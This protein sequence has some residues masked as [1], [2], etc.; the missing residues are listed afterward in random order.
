[1]SIEE[2]VK[3]SEK[4]CEKR[5]TGHFGNKSKIFKLIATPHIP[6][7]LLIKKVPYMENS[8]FYIEMSLLQ[9]SKW[10]IKW[11]T[12]RGTFGGTR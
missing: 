9:I 11:S 4:A 1:M 7:P 10:S 3:A 12:G 6:P 5:R 2:F 8:V